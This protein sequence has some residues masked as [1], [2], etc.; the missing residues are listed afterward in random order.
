MR[1]PITLELRGITEYTQIVFYT[2]GGDGDFGHLGKMEGNTVFTI[3]LTGNFTISFV[4]PEKLRVEK[5]A[6]GSAVPI[7]NTTLRVAGLLYRDYFSGSVNGS[8][9]VNFTPGVWNFTLCSGNLSIYS[10]L[11]TNITG[12]ADT[13][14]PRINQRYASGLIIRG[15]DRYAVALE[16][17]SLPYEVNIPPVC[18]LGFQHLTIGTYQPLELSDIFSYDP[19]GIIVKRFWDFG[20]GSNATDN[21][22]VHAYTAP[23]TYTL[24]LTVMDNANTTNTSYA[25]VEVLPM[26]TNISITPTQISPNTFKFEAESAANYSYVWFFGDGK[27]ATGN[28]VQHSFATSGRY[29]V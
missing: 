24:S 2:S 13:H 20:D 11:D 26:C 6:H 10:L 17:V 7:P 25:T 9:M 12:Y 19:D 3:P 16:P 14:N 15:N 4:A 29:L 22:T 28:P 21:H 5:V 18:T 1:K 8:V 23:G 27:N